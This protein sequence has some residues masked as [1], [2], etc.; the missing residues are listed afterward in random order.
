MVYIPPQRKHIWTFYAGLTVGGCCGCCNNAYSAAS[1]VG[2]NY[3]CD[4]GNLNG[5]DWRN[6]FFPAHP[7]WDGVSGCFSTSNTCCAPHSGPW[8]HVTLTTPTTES[9]EIR[10]C[11]EEPTTNEDTPLELIEIYV[12]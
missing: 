11:G 6:A 4:T 5:A 8:F 1:Q 3:F 9:I 12:K 10:I 7:L 2:E